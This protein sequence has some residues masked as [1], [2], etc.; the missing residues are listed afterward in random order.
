MCFFTWLI[1]INGER[2]FYVLL[3]SFFIVFFTGGCYASEEIKSPSSEKL[4]LSNKIVKSWPR[5]WEVKGQA[6]WD[7]KWLSASFDWHWKQ[8]GQETTFDISGPLGM[9]TVLTSQEDD[10]VIKD[11]DGSVDWG[12]S[13]AMTRWTG[14]IVV[15]KK[16]LATWLTGRSKSSD[17]Y[18]VRDSYKLGK[19]DIVWQ[20]W[21]REK[22][23][24]LPHKII[25]TSGPR[26]LEILVDNWD[27][28]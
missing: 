1:K 20:D 7:K 24:Y 26:Y 11:D 25:M 9:S 18:A 15:T 5:N 23:F 4:N 6:N 27:L 13:Q 14:G 10:L 21:S 3:N 2:C 17:P 8:T 28:K 12:V 16:M 22:G 19:L